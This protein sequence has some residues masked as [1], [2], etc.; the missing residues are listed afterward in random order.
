MVVL[1]GNPKDLDKELIVKIY[2]ELIPIGEKLVKRLSKVGSNYKDKPAEFSI[3][4]LQFYEEILKTAVGENIQQILIQ[5]LYSASQK[6]AS[7]EALTIDQ[8]KEQNKI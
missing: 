7:K 4:S 6:E 8:L 1:K 2:K 3:A 5:M